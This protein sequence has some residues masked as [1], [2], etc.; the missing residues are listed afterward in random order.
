MGEEKQ[1][2]ST[3]NLQPVFFGGT[4]LCV[5]QEIEVP[6]F[7][8]HHLVHF[9]QSRVSSGQ[10]FSKSS[11]DE[12]AKNSF[13]HTSIILYLPLFLAVPILKAAPSQIFA[14]LSR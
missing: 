14:A 11:L 13:E 1:K 9:P 4:K 3:Q 12:P 7:S 2:H 6:T 8:T 10:E 5:T